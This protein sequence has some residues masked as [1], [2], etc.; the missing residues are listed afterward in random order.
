MALTPTP[1]TCSH[2]FRPRR[3]WQVQNARLHSLERRRAQQLEA[4]NTIAQQMTVVLELRELLPKVCWLVEKAFQLD[5]VSVLLKEEEDL[6]L[7][8]HG[9][10]WTLRVPEIGGWR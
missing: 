6:G 7:R 4:I 8:A 3:R 1:S 2:C 9:G 5:H 10:R